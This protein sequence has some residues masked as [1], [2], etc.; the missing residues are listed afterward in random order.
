MI[1][2]LIVI[3]M[4]ISL[5]AG[6]LLFMWCAEKFKQKTSWWSIP[7]WEYSSDVKIYYALHWIFVITALHIAFYF[8]VT[9]ITSIVFGVLLIL[10]TY[11]LLRYAS[12]ARREYEERILS[13]TLF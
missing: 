2:M 8:S 10:S 3:A 6:H 5:W 9:V 11:F 4:V 7:I 13:K 12:I 1:R